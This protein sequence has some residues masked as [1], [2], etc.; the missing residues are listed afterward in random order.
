M[1]DAIPLNSPKLEILRQ[2]VEAGNMTAVETFWQDIRQNGAPLVE[3][4]AGDDQHSLVTFLWRA[5]DDTQ[6]IAVVSN[7]SGKMGAS[8]PMT[9]LAPTDLWYKTYRLP[10]DTRET[11]QFAVAGNHVSDPLN[12]HQHIFPD[13]AEVGLTGWVSSVLELPDA[14]PQ[15]WSK[16]RLNT[17][18]GQVTL[19]RV[20]SQF[21]N[22]EYRVWIYTPPGYNRES[23]PYGYLLILDGWF[24]CHLI[25][26]PTILDNL[27]ADG[28]LPPLIAIMVG[29]PWDPTRQRDLA[30]YPPFV[31]FVTQELLP[32]AQGN[33][34]L[35]KNPTQIGV[36]GGS[37]GGLAAAHLALEHPAL[38]GQVLAQSGAFSWKPEGE[39]EFYW[40]PRQ[41]AAVSPQLPL[42]FYLEAGR[43]ETAIKTDFGGEQD[44]LAASR[45]M[46]DVLRA[47]GYE[48]QYREFSSGHNPITWQGTLANG[49]IA[50]FGQ[51]G[52]NVEFFSFQ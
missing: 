31:N 14:P 49:L 2:A 39:S 4:I 9:R 13:D 34:P 7:L 26:T 1:E 23:A 6:T 27:L 3:P 35:T 48:V 24:Y 36:V 18:S 50:L 20:Y 22:N 38:F 51:E 21:L 29:H 32:W 44:F 33:Y 40:L 10:S 16:P 11:Y 47:K 5:T 25:P 19:Q 17:P 41:Y 37:R 52:K 43:F 15:P 8:E 28:L 12:P 30:C 42:R 45:Y 46:R